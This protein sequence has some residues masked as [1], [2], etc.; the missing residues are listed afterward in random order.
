MPATLGRFLPRGS[1]AVAAGA[2]VRLSHHRLF[3][4]MPSRKQAAVKVF[5]SRQA[6]VIGPTPPGTG[7][8]TPA[9]S[10]A[11]AKCTSPTHLVLPSSFGTRLIPTSNTAAP[12]SEKRSGGQGLVS[13]LLYRG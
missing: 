1:R 7:V 11:E 4:S 8:I 6:M 13:T 12:Q 3:G 10:P 2:T 5:C 9:V